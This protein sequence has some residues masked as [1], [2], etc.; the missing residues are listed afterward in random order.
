MSYHERY[1]G[2]YQTPEWK[3][4]RAEVFAEANGLCQ[5]CLVK[6]IIRAGKEIHHKIPIEK[7]FSRRFEKDNLVC[8]CPECHSA[9][10]KRGNNSPLQKFKKFWETM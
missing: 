9:E 3:N 6:G 4:L 8:L 7:D 1:N 10:H 2:F 5:H